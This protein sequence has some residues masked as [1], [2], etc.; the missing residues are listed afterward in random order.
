MAFTITTLDPFETDDINLIFND[1][2]YATRSVGRKYTKNEGRIS[3]SPVSVGKALHLLCPD[4]FPLWDSKIA[5]NYRC[6]WKD[7]QRSHNNYM[8]FIKIA[9][10]QVKT[11]QG[12]SEVPKTLSG[13]GI[14]KLIDEYNYVRFTKNLITSSGE[15]IN[16]G[17]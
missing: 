1:M 14:L 8:D 11:L 17:M 5:E 4:F 15:G 6:K 2:L 3:Y 7:S 12:R 16:R 9:S 10:T 13:T